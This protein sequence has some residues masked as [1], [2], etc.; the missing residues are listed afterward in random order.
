MAA[1]TG[2]YF[3]RLIFR[4]AGQP[5]T[6]ALTGR[7]D[8]L[9]KEALINVIEKKYRDAV[10]KKTRDDISVL[11]KTD[12]V[13]VPN[14]N[15]ILT[16]PLQISSVT[17]VTTTITVVTK[18]PHNL[19]ANQSVTIAGA[20][21]IT[22]VN[23]TFTIT[24]ITN[25]TTFTYTNTAPVGT[26][27]ANTGTVTYANMLTD[28]YHVLNIKAKF[29]DSITDLNVISAT[30]ATPIRITFD[31]YN[32][33]RT[34][35]RVK[36]EGVTGNTA[37]N[38]EGYLKQLN[39][40]DFTFFSDRFLRQGIAATGDYISGGTISRVYYEECSFT[41]SATKNAELNKP[42]VDTPQYEIAERMLKILPNDITCTEIT[43]DYMIVPP[44][45]IV[46]TD[47][48][49]DLTNTYPEKLLLLVAEEAVKLFG[50]AS[51]DTELRQVSQQNE[52]INQ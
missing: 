7:L 38:T 42:Y 20:A 5:Y 46:S 17:A 50:E 12:K 21:G 9:I 28:Y 49:Y 11:I 1:F 48:A 13:F 19:I 3:R 36:V 33:L 23:G 37:A 15:K 30:N 2:D 18:L 51:G 6:N 41:P 25:S 45:D 34:N 27:T 26:H 47:T 31:F 40:F 4:K 35:D 10:N 52:Q 29:L 24:G 8:A 16:A 39:K 14:N 22:N 43:V 32:N 44:V